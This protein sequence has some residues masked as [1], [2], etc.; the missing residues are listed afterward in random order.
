M[1]NL[2]VEPL[3]C[4][5]FAPYGRVLDNLKHEPTKAGDGWTCFSPIDFII[6]DAPLG[7][8]IVYCEKYPTAITAMERHVSREELLWATT[9]DLVMG[10]DLPMYLG[11]EKAR[12]NAGTTKVFLIKA[13]QAVIMNRGTWHTPAFTLK[14][15]SKYFFAIERKADF[16]DQDRQPW[17]RFQNEEIVSI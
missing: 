3:S 4:I 14:D 17:I 12:P 2:E 1:K 10:V 7:I 5:S 11:D 13:G 8:G 9:E 16:V 15:S 6:T